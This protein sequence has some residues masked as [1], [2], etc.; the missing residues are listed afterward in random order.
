MKKNTLSQGLTLAPPVFLLVLSVAIFTLCNTSA[1]NETPPA[2]SSEIEGR[3]IE[4]QYLEKENALREAI[5]AERFDE[6]R[7][8]LSE[9]RRILKTETPAVSSE[10]ET[11][12]YGRR[13]DALDQYLTRRED[14]YRQDQ[15]NRQRIEVL[16]DQHHQ[17]QEQRQAVCEQTRA[18]LEQANVLWSRQQYPEAA[19]LVRKIR[20]L[21]PTCR[22]A[23]YLEII[24]AKHIVAD[25]SI[26]ESTL[27]TKAPERDRSPTSPSRDD[28]FVGY[29][30]AKKWAMISRRTPLSPPGVDGAERKDLGRENQLI[31]QLARTITQLRFA[32]GTTF[33]QIV[34]WLQTQAQLDVVPDWHVLEEYGVTPDTELPASL[35][36]HDVT[37]ETVLNI[38]LKQLSPGEPKAR[39]DWDFPGGVVVISTRQNLHSADHRYATRL[40]VYDVSDLLHTIPPRGLPGLGRYNWDGASL[41][42]PPFNTGMMRAPFNPNKTDG[43]NVS[44]VQGGAVE[45]GMYPRSGGMR[46]GVGRADY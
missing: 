9:T 25:R 18:W 15:A 31:D 44:G 40:K 46:M 30:D 36:L 6:A 27:V 33:A 4:K 41:M 21:D 2:S 37:L 13:L 17:R 39:L 20:T 12:S 10:V 29:P 45:M 5:R 32:E 14:Q 35:S 3:T 34:S 24:L 8:L 19:Q 26:P 43:Y 7:A 42:G 23:Q 11:G 16:T 1:A 38:V 28:S 22:E